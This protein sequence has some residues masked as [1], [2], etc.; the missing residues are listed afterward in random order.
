MLSILLKQVGLKGEAMNLISHHGVSS[1][2][3]IGGA[4]ATQGQQP[5]KW[6]KVKKNSDN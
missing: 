1:V 6:Y 5:L 2:D 3:W 4:L